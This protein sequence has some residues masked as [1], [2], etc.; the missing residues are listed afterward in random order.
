MY[1]K[2]LNDINFEAEGVPCLKASFAHGIRV[3]CTFGPCKVFF[4]QVG[5]C[6]VSEFEF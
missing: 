5:P 1:A 6:K 2:T 4:E 3:K